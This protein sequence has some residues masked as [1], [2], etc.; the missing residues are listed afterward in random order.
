MQNKKICLNMIVKDETPVITRCL[1]S[2]VGFIDRYVIVDTGSSDGTPEMIRSF[3]EEKGI[4]GVVYEEPWVNFEHNRNQALQLAYDDEESDYAFFIDADEIFHCESA[5]ALK[6][7]IDKASASVDYFLIEKR[8]GGMRYGL[9]ALIDLKSGF[10]WDWVGVVHEALTPQVIEGK[11]GPKVAKVEF[12]HIS[13]RHGEGVRSRGKSLEEKFLAD[14]E[15]LEGYLQEN[16]DDTRHR[17]YLAQSYRDAG[18]LDKA[19]E[20]Y[21]IRATMGGWNEEVYYC[22]YQIGSILLRNDEYPSAVAYMLN[23]CAQHRLRSLEPL[24]GLLK[25]CRK[26]KMHKE[27]NMWGAFG[28]SFLKK[29]ERDILFVPHDVYAYGFEDEYAISLAESGN[30]YEGFTYMNK[31]LHKQNID[32]EVRERIFRNTVLVLQRLPALAKPEMN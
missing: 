14:A 5:P 26:N 27:A 2:L 30:H 20:N 9:P 23:A 12:C 6:N 19:M 22:H 11:P 16:P 24:Y 25:Y 3:M 28:M 4:P 29:P 10:R 21:K 18:K 1:S 32:G 8:Y 13:A 31:L 7:F 15:T 17:F